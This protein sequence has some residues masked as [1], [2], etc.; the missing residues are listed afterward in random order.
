MIFN[1]REIFGSRRT[2]LLACGKGAL[3]SAGGSGN[4]GSRSVG[5]IPRHVSALAD[6]SNTSMTVTI[7]RLRFLPPL[8]PRGFFLLVLLFWMGALKEVESGGW[9][10]GA[11]KYRI[12]F[13]CN[14]FNTLTEGVVTTQYLFTFLSDRRLY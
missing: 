12:P 11:S 9:L 7:F 13:V 10:E 14:D 2:L 1:L 3:D 6:R 8:H 4:S 5:S